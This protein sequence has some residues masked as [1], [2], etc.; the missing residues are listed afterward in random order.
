LT[1]G[2]Q[3]VVKII[4]ESLSQHDEKHVVPTP[5][6][7]IRVGGRRRRLIYVAPLIKIGDNS[8]Y[9]VQKNTAIKYQTEE[10]FPYVLLFELPIHFLVN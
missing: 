7:G 9:I 8:K 6:S 4:A 3:P 2:R 1:S 5:L 10:F